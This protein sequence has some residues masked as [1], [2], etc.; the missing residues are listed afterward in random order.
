MK[1]ALFILACI[2]S[3]IV[4]LLAALWLIRRF[5]PRRRGT[6]VA[7]NETATALL[8][9]FNSIAGS[10]DAVVSEHNAEKRTARLFVPFGDFGPTAGRDNRD[11]KT[12]PTMQK[13]DL[14]AANAIIARLNS[15]RG[16]LARKLRLIP[17][18]EGHPDVPGMEDT[19][20][21][22]SAKGWIVGANVGANDG[23]DGLFFDAEMTPAGMRMILDEE[24]AFNSPRWAMAP[25]TAANEAVQIARPAKIIS[26][27]LTNT[28]FIEGAL[29][30]A[31]DAMAAEAGTDS[32]FV[33]A[34]TLAQLLGMPEETP[35]LDLLKRIGELVAAAIKPEEKP[36]EKPAE[37]DPA[38]AAATAE[39]ANE[40]ALALAATAKLTAAEAQITAANNALAA[41]TAARTQLAAQIEAANAA[42]VTA[43]EEA[44]RLTASLEAVNTALATERKLRAGEIVDRAIEDGRV[45]LADRDRVVAEIVAANCDAATVGRIEHAKPVVKTS[46]SIGGLGGRHV[47]GAAHAALVEQAAKMSGNFLTNYL[48]LKNG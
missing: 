37:A 2:L 41:E 48:S 43:R 14:E 42:T 4:P 29:N 25:I 45:L 38:V 10:A 9:A 19:Y 23:R 17:I 3:F 21:D 26:F 31:N 15:L 16:T 20:R 39:A 11:G 35:M 28:P 32:P 7:A 5:A 18:Y 44:A 33:D 36:V 34:P 47:T 8:H 12:K 27:G 1:F 40:R 13:F 46:S 30:M 22:R 24:F 6:I